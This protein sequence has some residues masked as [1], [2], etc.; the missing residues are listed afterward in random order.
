MDS[1]LLFLSELVDAGHKGSLTASGRVV[2]ST[3][4]ARPFA[5]LGIRW[6]VF[7]LS[8]MDAG[9]LG[10]SVVIATGA[11]PSV[12]KEFAALGELVLT[13]ETLFELQSLV[14]CAGDRSSP[15]ILRCFGRYAAY[16]INGPESL[17][18]SIRAGN[19]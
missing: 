1:I 8:A 10:G 3:K 5:R 9:F 15:H 19:P 16:N 11:R 7:S 18:N 14:E 12:P 2:R 13:N 4:C 6:I 17:Q